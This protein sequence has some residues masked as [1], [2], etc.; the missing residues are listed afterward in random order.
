MAQ[1]ILS[2]PLAT[3]GAARESTGWLKLLNNG[4]ISTNGKNGATAVTWQRKWCGFCGTSLCCADGPLDDPVPT[5]DLSNCIRVGRSTASD[6]AKSGEIEL[7]CGHH[8]H[9]VRV[10][11]AKN[12]DE[13]S[14]KKRYG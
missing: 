12:E 13:A 1:I 14:S 7:T 11:V 3:A 6:K 2:G 10:P 5:I 4:D 9:R 8:I